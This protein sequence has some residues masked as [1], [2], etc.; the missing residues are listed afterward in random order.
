MKFRATA[1]FCSQRSRSPRVRQLGRKCELTRGK[2]FASSGCGSCHT[3]KAADAKGQVGP[4]LDELKPDAST[5]EHQVRV[6]GNGMPSFGSKLTSR[7]ITLVADF[8][9]DSSRSS[10]K[11]AAFKPDDTTVAGC[12]R[13]KAG[14]A[15]FRRAFGERRLQRW[16]GEGAR[17]ARQG[18]PVDPGGSRRLPPDLARESATGRWPTSRTTRPK[19]SPTEG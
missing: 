5:V 1:A 16:P 10:S 12:E 6:G 4:N 7:Q 2:L 3:L 14:P 11:V 19:R 13:E 9:A 18:R 17:A 8:V 15:C